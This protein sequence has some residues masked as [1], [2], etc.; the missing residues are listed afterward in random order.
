MFKK[1][2]DLQMASTRYESRLKMLRADMN[3]GGLVDGTIEPKSTLSVASVL[4]RL[5]QRLVSVFHLLM[6]KAE[7]HKQASGRGKETMVVHP[8]SHSVSLNV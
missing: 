6:N 3:M 7:K 1:Q 4:R 8:V 5:V 2:K